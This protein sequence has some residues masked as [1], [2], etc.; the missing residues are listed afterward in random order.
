M[1]MKSFLFFLSSLT[2]AVSTD[3]P[4]GF[5][6]D[7]SWPVHSYELK[8]GDLLGDRQSVYEDYMEGC[9]KCY[10]K[11]GRRCDTTEDDR[12]EMSVRQPQSMVVSVA[13]LC[14]VHDLIIDQHS[15]AC[16]NALS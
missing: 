5:G 1:L 6:V 10:G 4:E 12:I 15:H 11:K 9:R 16:C 3:E 8:C 2:L 13:P 7:C 14:F